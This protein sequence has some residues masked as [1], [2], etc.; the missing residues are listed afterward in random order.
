M[1]IEP[2]DEAIVVAE[3]PS[4]DESKA[5]PFVEAMS[6]R[7]CCEGIDED[8]FDVGV[9]ETAGERQVHDPGSVALAEVGGVANPEI[10]RAAI[11]RH[12]APVVTFFPRGIDDLQKSDWSTVE[13]R[14]ELLAPVGS[15]PQFFLPV[16]IVVGVAGDDVGLFVPM[17]K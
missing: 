5:E 7:V 1:A 13:F 10:D 15:A 14:N 8:R 11:G 3:S 17:L 12:V 6:T 4:F 2:I 9:G 16:P